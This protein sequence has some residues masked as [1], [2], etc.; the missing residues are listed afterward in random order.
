MLILEGDANKIGSVRKK[1]IVASAKILGLRSDADVLV[2]ENSDFPDSMTTDWDPEKVAG[3][4][5]SLFTKASTRGTRKP[6]SEA[7]QSKAP[8]TTIDVLITFDA[9]GISGHRNH[10]SLYNGARAW[11]RDLVRGR[12]DGESPVVLYTLTSTNIAR[13]YM[14]ALDAPLTIISCLVQD[15]R[16]A[17]RTAQRDLPPH[18]IFLSDWL[19]YNR[20]QRAMTK[21]HKS[22]MVWFRWGWIGIGRYMVVNDLKRE[23][24]S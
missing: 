22:Q 13:K 24:I 16:S 23:R 8:E 15:L 14:S 9:G 12:T 7:P 20:A 5:S 1:E 17:G 4:L 10:I 19:Y 3:V 21:A 6:A 11:L 2:Y 18:L